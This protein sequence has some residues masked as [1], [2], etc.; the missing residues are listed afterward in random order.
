[1]AIIRPVAVARKGQ[2][3]GERVRKGREVREDGRMI[4]GADRQR[5]LAPT[6]TGGG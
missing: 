1:M 4:L 5:Q 2:G 6:H 3:Q